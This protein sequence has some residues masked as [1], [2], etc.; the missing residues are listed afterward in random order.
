MSEIS[1]S[2]TSDTS[3]FTTLV[4]EDAILHLRVSIVLFKASRA[5]IDAHQPDGDFEHIVARGKVDKAC[6]DRFDASDDGR[7][8]VEKAL[9]RVA[10][11]FRHGYVLLV[12]REVVRRSWV[13][14]KGKAQAL[15]ARHAVAASVDVIHI[16]LLS[17]ALSFLTMT[18]RT[19]DAVNSVIQ[20]RFQA[21]QRYLRTASSFQYYA[22]L[23][24][25]NS[26]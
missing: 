5:C 1:G 2:S 14:E 7:R 6:P 26:K 16:L 17:L 18:M 24:E 21:S 9:L 13:E 19:I 25:S 12:G 8:A 20:W 3:A 4:N 22:T 15:V 23:L 11:V 10:A